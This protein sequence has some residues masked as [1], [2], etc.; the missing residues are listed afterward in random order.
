V[1]P[2]VLRR[3]LHLAIFIGIIV[4]VRACGG[5]ATAEDQLGAGTQWFAERTGLAAAK[6]KWDESIRP[7]IAAMTDAA[8]QSLYRGVARTL[9]NAEAAADEGATWVGQVIASAADSV[10]NVLRA[11]FVP[12]VEPAPQKPNS[13]R[14]A[15]QA[16]PPAP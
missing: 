9:D 15:Q 4:G 3:L 16:A 13:P 11:T 14:Q 1:D 6:D 5:A 2:G 10:T 12:G 7:P 8:S